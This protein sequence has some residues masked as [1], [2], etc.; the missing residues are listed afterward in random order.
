MGL[1]CDQHG[2]WTKKN[3]GSEIKQVTKERLLPLAF[4]TNLAMA[5]WQGNLFDTT[6]LKNTT[7]GGDDLTVSELSTTPQFRWMGDVGDDGPSPSSHSH[8]GSRSGVLAT[9]EYS[10]EGFSLENPVDESFQGHQG[11]TSALDDEEGEGDQTQLNLETIATANA[12]AKDRELESLTY[13]LK[14]MNQGIV[15]LNDV[16]RSTIPKFQ[17]GDFACYG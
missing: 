15:R 12:D 16:L 1:V 3:F 2:T 17:V 11:E 7:H 4:P 9:Q 6:P 14:K 5:H 13:T 8:S 10:T